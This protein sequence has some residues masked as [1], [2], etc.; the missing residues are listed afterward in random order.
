MN[1]K[2]LYA[3]IARE[4]D[5][6][7]VEPALWT[8]AFGEADGDRDRAKAI[9]IRLRKAELEAQPQPGTAA[10]APAAELEA[11][12]RELA[13]ALEHSSRESLYRTLDLD[14]TSSDAQIAAAVRARRAR[15]SPPGAAERYA[16]E[17]LGDPAERES[18]DRRLA[19]RFGLGAAVGEDTPAFAGFDPD[20]SATSVFLEWWATR[21]VTVLVATATAVLLGYL[22]HA[23]YQTRASHEQQLEAVSVQK[24]QALGSI[25]LA[26]AREERARLAEER[27]LQQA[28]EAARRTQRYEEERMLEQARRELRENLQAYEAR[29]RQAA[30]EK[31]LLR[32][33]EHRRR[34]Q[35][36]REAELA[37]LRAQREAAYWSC[38]NDAIDRRDSAYAT[39]Y[40][41][42]L[43]Q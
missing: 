31:E 6:D 34:E 18:Y 5:S 29:Q 7:G 17:V 40:C 19:E 42:Y 27:R 26:R 3:R 1:E 43:L 32:I 21:K 23:F 33:A 15:E 30:R 24:A 38:F 16:F 22:M 2:A 13:S 10:D 41:A 9:Y 25:E 37:R 20:R 14:A 8:K 4:I 11:L 35:A 12:R 28:A 36:A 39:E